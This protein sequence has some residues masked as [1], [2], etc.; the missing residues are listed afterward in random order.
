[1]PASAYS[2]VQFHASLP[3]DGEGEDRGGAGL[4]HM[5]MKTA[6]GTFREALG[7]MPPGHNL[8]CLMD[9]PC[10]SLQLQHSLGVFPEDFSLLLW[11]EWQLTDGADVLLRIE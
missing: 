2:N 8:S 5:P 4:A 11:G 7:R 10:L 1:M 9:F 3:L 6:L